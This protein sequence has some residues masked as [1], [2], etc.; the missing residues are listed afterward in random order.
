MD[1]QVKRWLE[2]LGLGQYAETFIAND[3]DLRALIHLTDDDLKDLGLSLGHR[4]IVL[5]AIKDLRS[6]DS[7]N[8]SANQ[9]AGTTQTQP[10]HR[11]LTVMFCDLVGFTELTHAM[12]PE[13]MRDLV[14]Q[15]Q[16]IV[17][18]A[19]RR[20]DGYIAK[21]LGDGILGY[22]GWPQAHED[23]ADRAV[24]AA[25][26]I[27][28]AIAEQNTTLEKRLEVRV[29]I[30]TGHV[31]VGDLVGEGVSD[32]EAV[33]GE[34]PNL[35][36][37][38]QSMAN[39]GQVLIGDTTRSLLSRMFELQD[40]G[41]Q[42]LK[43][44]PEPVQSWRVLHEIDVESR[45]LA[46]HSGT[47]TARVGRE[48]ELGLLLERWQV[49]ASGEG[50]VVLVSGEAGIGKSRIVQ[51]MRSEIGTSPYKNYTFQ[52][53][54]HRT[55]SAFFPVIQHLRQAAG[56]A[57]EDSR[58]DKLDK[59]ETL[60]RSEGDAVETVAPVFAAILSL[61]AED[62]YGPL[63]MSPQ[64]LRG[65]AIELLIRQ[66]VRA[67]RS[68]PVLCVVEDAHWIDPSMT[69]LVGELVSAVSNSAACLVITYRPGFEP[70]WPSYPHVSSVELSRLGQSQAEKIVQSVAGTDL[71][72]A[73]VDQIVQRSDGV[74]LYAEELTK[75]VLESVSSKSEGSID[76]VIPQTLESSLISRLDRLKDAKEV[77]QVG[78]VIGRDFSHEMVI[79]V[80]DEDPGAIEDKLD[81]LVTSGLVVRRGTPPTAV[82]SFKHSLVQD[83]AYS[84]I[85][86]S[87]R[88]GLHARIVEVME[89]QL[90]E[91]VSERV[92]TLSHHAYAGEIWDKAFAYLAAAGS[93]A[94][95]RSALHEAAAQFKNALLAAGNL[96]K[97]TANQI[98]TLDVKFELRNALWALGRF[99]D[100]LTHLAEAE[101]IAAELMDPVRAGWISVFKSASNWQLGR[102]SAAIEAA[103]AALCT[104]DESENLSLCVA[105]NFYLGCA[106]ITSGDTRKAET[107][108]QA[109]TDQLVGDLK[110]EQCGLPFAPAVIA[111]SWIIWA[112]SE[113][114]RFKQGLKI[115]EEGID[116]AM[117]LQHP[118]NL[119]HIYY[120]V[121]CFYD[122]KGDVEQAVAAHEKSYGFVTSWGLTYL[123][124]FIMGFLG[125]A[126][127][128]AGRHEEGIS[129][130]DRAQDAYER[131]G[132]G[133][134]RSLIGVHR[135]EAYFLTGDIERARQLTQ[136][137][138][139]LA[140]K[141]GERGH[142]A[143]ALRL[144]GNIS[145]HDKQPDAEA[146]ATYFNDALTLANAHRMR[147]LIAQC[148]LCLGELLRDS[149][150]RH[151]V[152]EEHIQT[153]IAM[154]RDMDMKILPH[155]YVGEA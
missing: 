70:A 9:P 27:V 53:S 7:S 122:T 85:L 140:R 114:G 31:V 151:E 97:D 40:L 49:S 139:S 95:Q 74:P 71:M 98:K 19:V 16:N 6:D 82:Y 36:F 42:T 111:R 89:K 152:G 61:P 69:E 14:Q 88:R 126:Y 150:N 91:Q 81:R 135:G 48:H 38:L 103:D 18:T 25:L 84:T 64:Q 92:D 143:H 66:V 136:D 145:L 144:L 123:S 109:V 78:A 86:R 56:F 37:R 133:L 96:P 34:T 115:V 121:G 117:E 60:L 44:F 22:F 80:L 77:A 155:I 50:Q 119:A 68:N 17:T 128:L 73:L 29:G 39:P 15:Y 127:A 63:D 104:G 153:G 131:I 1:N 43:G 101:K 113:R 45:F 26:N 65:K 118:F 58:S 106:Y 32:T 138:L 51:E 87:R 130:L 134:F 132:L 105:A 116:L 5:A 100:I 54:P 108:F 93:R 4:R 41:R 47:L 112:L 12:D 21:F 30:E 83:A 10:E 110:A 142:E 33:I 13:E 90:G 8:G 149:K 59:L 11:Q 35:A 75:S 2:S 107:Y 147:P 62:R 146:A 120:D 20:Y 148:H 141:R 72:S 67:S 137:A 79:S 99:E 102:S 55:N 3:V 94:M 124:P 46:S 28:D 129:F 57:N 125:H 24:R 23:E 76:H 52:C 154:A